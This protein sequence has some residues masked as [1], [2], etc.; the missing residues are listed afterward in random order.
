MNLTICRQKLG[1]SNPL[2]IPLPKSTVSEAMSVLHQLEK[3]AKENDA[4]IEVMFWVDDLD[5][6]DTVLVPPCLN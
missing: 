2:I 3:S 4:G 5:A 1:N 6:P